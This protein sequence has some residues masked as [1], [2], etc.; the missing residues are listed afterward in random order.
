M[1]DLEIL[2]TAIA[3]IECPKNALFR[4]QVIISLSPKTKPTAIGVICRDCDSCWCLEQIG[5]EWRVTMHI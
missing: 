2:E 1:K 5:A 3:C 4:I